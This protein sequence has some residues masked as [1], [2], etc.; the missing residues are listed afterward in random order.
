MVDVTN[1]AALVY[2]VAACQYRRGGWEV[3]MAAGIRSE[4]NSRMAR[5]QMAGISDFSV[6]SEV[7]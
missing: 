3:I 1:H 7:V 6:K 5:R 4:S 2:L